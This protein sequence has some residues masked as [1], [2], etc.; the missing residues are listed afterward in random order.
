MVLSGVEGKPASH[1]QCSGPGW[2][3][4]RGEGRGKCKYTLDYK[5]LVQK[6]GVKISPLFIL[7]TYCRDS[8][9][10]V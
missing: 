4:G 7:S 1:S 3:G 10:D 6:K 8:I 5:G 9:L 2:E